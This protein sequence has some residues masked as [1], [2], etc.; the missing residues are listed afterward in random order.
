MI[1]EESYQWSQ[2]QW[3]EDEEEV[4]KSMLWKEEAGKAKREY[5]R[6]LEEVEK[7]GIKRQTV[8]DLI[9]AMAPM[10]RK[11]KMKSLN[12]KRKKKEA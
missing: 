9:K 1:I 11:K 3:E 4:M 10:R 2:A 8:E 6:V 5:F 12:H 7:D